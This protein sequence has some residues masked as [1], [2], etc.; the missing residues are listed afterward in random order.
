M[1]YDSTYM[2]FQKNNSVRIENRLV[3]AEIWSER[4]LDYKEL[5]WGKFWSD[6]T[7]LYVT[8]MV[9]A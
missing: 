3:I 1:F 4:G 2:T 5:A 8:V 6:G 9:E 7:V